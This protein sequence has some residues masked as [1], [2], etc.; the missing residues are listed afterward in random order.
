MLVLRIKNTLFH[1]AVV[2]IFLV[3]T[4]LVTT[5]LLTMLPEG[6]QPTVFMMLCLIYW[7]IIDNVTMAIDYATA[8]TAS[9]ACRASEQTALKLAVAAIAAAAASR[10]RAGVK[11]AVAAA[12]IAT[13]TAAA[14][15]KPRLSKWHSA[16]QL[17]HVA[18]ASARFGALRQPQQLLRC[19]SAAA[20]ATA[21][22]A[23]SA[24]DSR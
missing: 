4:S 24:R 17:Q 19:A 22:A 11:S 6:L 3:S 16:P 9:S 18:A 15:D 14:V 12:A 5:K 8:E 2:G 7:L 21:A 20:A 10:P 13:A 1:L 23:A